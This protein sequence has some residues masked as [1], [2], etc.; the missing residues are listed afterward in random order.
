[1]IKMR[2]LTVGTL[3]SVV[4][5]LLLGCASAPQVAQG[6]RQTRGGIIFNDQERSVLLT[7]S[8]VPQKVRVQSIGTDSVN[9]VRIVTQDELRASGFSGVGY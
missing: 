3:A 1:M 8:N 7:G 4:S 5:L 2:W 9:N 6:P